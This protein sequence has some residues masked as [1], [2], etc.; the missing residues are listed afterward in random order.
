MEMDQETITTRRTTET[1]GALS[2]ACRRLIRL[3]LAIN[4]GRIEDLAFRKGE[5]VFDPPPRLI[6]TV[7]LSGKNGPRDDLAVADLARHPRV[8]A[9][10]EQLALRGSGIIRKL[11]IQDGIPDLM[12]I[13]PE[14]QAQGLRP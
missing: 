4:F 1:N 8:V 6:Y 9:L 12:D 3:F 10:F 5:P 13:E 14:D 11:T 7:K 2:S